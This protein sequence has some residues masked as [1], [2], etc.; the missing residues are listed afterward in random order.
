MPSEVPDTRCA[1]C[2]RLFE[3]HRDEPHRCTCG[4]PLELRSPLRSPSTLEAPVSNLWAFSA[5]FPP[6]QRIELGAGGTPLVDVPEYD[7]SFKLETCNPTGSFKDRGAALTLSRASA[8]GVEHLREDS[9]GNAGR[10]IATY[11][12]RAGID[13]HIYVPSHADTS[14]VATIEATGANVIAVDGGRS[15]AATACQ[16]ASGWYASHAWRPEFYLG[17]ATCAWELIAD[18]HGCPPDALVLPVGHG[19]LLLGLY[20]GF[21]ALLEGGTIERLPQL[22]AAQL[23]G[24]GSLTPP[25]DASVDPSIA[26]GVRIERPARQSQV[27]QA[28]DTSGGEVITVD[29]SDVTE[30][31]RQLA[32]IGF[33]MCSTAALGVVARRALLE[34]GKLP[35]TADVIVPI[36]GRSR[37]R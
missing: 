25:T 11:A 20:R 36:T 15:A 9:S 10:A 1:S 33:D 21:K 32:A 27:R 3:A 13:A 30:G 8:L 35:D 6:G 29:P 24:A 7:A 18:R 14:T 4:G 12:A 19:T 26:P 23:A 22:Y 34:R 17:T 28:I 16:H 5:S 2:D 37:D 31:R